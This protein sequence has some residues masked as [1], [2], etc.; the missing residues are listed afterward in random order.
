M[1]RYLLS[2]SKLR[3]LGNWNLTYFPGSGRS[4]CLTSIRTLLFERWQVTAYHWISMSENQRYAYR[5]LKTIQMKLSF[6]CVWTE[7]VILGSAKTSLE[8]KYDI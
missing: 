3:V 1:S 6:S 2:N 4:K 8:F 7:P 5:V